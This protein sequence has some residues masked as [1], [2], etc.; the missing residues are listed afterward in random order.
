MALHCQPQDS[1]VVRLR[2]A[3]GGNAAHRAPE[4]TDA[5]HATYVHCQPAGVVSRCDAPYVIM[6]VVCV[7]VCVRVSVCPCVRVSVCPCVRVSVR[8]CVRVSVCPSVRLSVCLCDAVCC[9][10]ARAL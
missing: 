1:D 3:L 8:L 5:L 4:V 2:R 7:C 9:A 6:C 10:A